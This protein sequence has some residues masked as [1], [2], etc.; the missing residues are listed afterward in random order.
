MIQRCCNKNNSS[1]HN[2]G[3]RG[4]GVYKKW[5]DDFNS[6]VN[7]VMSLPNAMAKGY[8]IDRIDND[9]HYEPGNI[10]WAT[11]T[12]QAMNKRKIIYVDSGERDED[13]CIIYNRID[14]DTGEL[15]NREY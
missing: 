10:R 4:I 5:K 8:T 12:E 13:D 9:G 15:C 11:G 7:Y 14:A 1:F 3:G 2:Y 6:Y